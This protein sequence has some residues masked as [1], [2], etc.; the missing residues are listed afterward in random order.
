VTAVYI[1]IGAYVGIIAT[2]IVMLFAAHALDKAE[3]S[4]RRYE[5]RQLRSPQ[6]RREGRAGGHFK[7]AN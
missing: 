2:C 5:R 6:T 1:A 3:A 4:L 7:L